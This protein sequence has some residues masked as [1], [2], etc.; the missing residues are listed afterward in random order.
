MDT[1][2]YLIPTVFFSCL[3]VL[4]AHLL[5]LYQALLFEE[6]EEFS[7]EHVKNLEM[8]AFEDSGCPVKI[9]ISILND[10]TKTEKEWPK[11]ERL[12]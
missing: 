11:K 4:V 7:A 12:R 2:M 5:P 8:R 3:N 9:T 1:L 10:K 6:M